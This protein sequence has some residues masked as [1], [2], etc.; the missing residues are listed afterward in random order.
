MASGHKHVSSE[1]S[2]FA[3]T[4]H[5]NNN[6]SKIQPA[7]SR[8]FQTKERIVYARGLQVNQQNLPYHANMKFRKLFSRET[9]ISGIIRKARRKSSNDKDA[10][11]SAPIANS[12]K[13]QSP[14]SKEEI[15]AKEKLSQQY[16]EKEATRRT[17]APAKTNLSDRVSSPRVSASSVATPRTP[18]NKSVKA[19]QGSNVKGKVL[20]TPRKTSIPIK[21]T[22]P[23]LSRPGGLP[24]SQQLTDD[25]KKIIDLKEKCEKF[26]NE[27]DSM[28]DDLRNKDVGIEAFIIIIKQHIKMIEE[29]SRN[30]ESVNEKNDHLET[31]LT[32]TS[33]MLETNQKR[34][35]D[36]EERLEQSSR[37][38]KKQIESLKKVHNLEIERTI[39]ELKEEEQLKIQE[40]TNTLNKKV[41]DLKE[42]CENE[43]SAL[44]HEH[45]KMKQDFQD[46]HIIALKEKE[47][48]YIKSIEEMKLRSQTEK[49]E[50]CLDYEDRLQDLHNQLESTQENLYDLEAKNGK[51]EEEIEKSIEG[52]LQGE[53]ARYKNLP[54]ELES[55]QSVVDLKN[56]QLKKARTQNMELQKKVEDFYELEKKFQKV[57]QEKEALLMALQNKTKC[58]RQLSVERESLA[59]DL[60]M[61]SRKVK[62]L[63]MEKEELMW[64]FNNSNSSLSLSSPSL[65]IDPPTS[66]SN[67]Q[68]TPNSSSRSFGRGRSHKTQ[69]MYLPTLD[70]EDYT[71]L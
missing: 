40:V 8:Y 54:A 29:S 66:P 19:Q 22:I 53:L 39:Q 6:L 5:D 69:S 43:V 50:V 59:A 56:E 14:F 9:D 61:E 24:S 33:N 47:Q 34:L 62:R 63:S 48:H 20:E 11:K 23:K 71:L 65:N 67:G 31:E 52:R 38:Y 15:A 58:E 21:S 16:V 42:Q 46:K 60:E 26:E 44:K 55:L 36:I 18:A 25:E 41:E 49:E 37:D 27:I 2:V 57:Y 4:A 12:K 68:S 30:L 10:R 32:D 7:P 64:K 1:Q 35:A 51:L 17:S 45:E 13:R 28:K 3:T 70:D